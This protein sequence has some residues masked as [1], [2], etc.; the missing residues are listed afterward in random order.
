MDQFLGQEMISR[1]QHSALCFKKRLARRR[2]AVKPVDL[3]PQ[4]VGAMHRSIASEETV[5]RLD[6]CRPAWQRLR[7]PSDD[8]RGQLK[9]V[10]FLVG[11]RGKQA[12][13]GAFQG[14][15]SLGY[16]DS[17]IRR[18]GAPSCHE[19]RITHPLK[20]VARPVTGDAKLKPWIHPLIHFA[21]LWHGTSPAAV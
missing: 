15:R 12:A 7:R 6:D 20:T 21:R 19:L 4:P 11:K 13:S 3:L 9:V 17:M 1:I 10:R 2:R 18:P 5:I 16:D 8:R 14:R